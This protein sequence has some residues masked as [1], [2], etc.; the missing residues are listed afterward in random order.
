VGGGGGGGGGVRVAPDEWSCTAG[1]KRRVQAPAPGPQGT[2]GARYAT[3]LR[4]MGR[5]KVQLDEGDLCDAFARARMERRRGPAKRACMTSRAWR[6]LSM[7]TSDRSLKTLG[8]SSS[9]GDKVTKPGTRLDVLQHSRAFGQCEKHVQPVRQPTGVQPVVSGS[10]GGGGA[11]GGGKGLL[12][13]GPH[14]WNLHSW[15]YTKRAKSLCT[16][17]GIRLLR[18]GLGRTCTML[19]T[20]TSSVMSLSK[21][22]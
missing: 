2:E 16:T 15:L 10:N 7:K 12:A 6:G 19:A 18:D 14:G 13:G 20:G 5:E 17:S 22:T 4:G 9:M 8:R 11:G 3:T 1:L 21:M